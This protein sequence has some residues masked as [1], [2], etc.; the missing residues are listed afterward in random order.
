MVEFWKGLVYLKMCIFAHVS[1]PNGTVYLPRGTL[2]LVMALACANPAGS[3][4]LI[5]NLYTAV[6]EGHAF[7][8]FGVD[9]VT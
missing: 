7:C 9:L 4:V 8:T 6:W 5:G 1:F 3:A 2:I